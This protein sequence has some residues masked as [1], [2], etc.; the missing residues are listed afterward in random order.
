MRFR[1]YRL[2]CRAMGPSLD[3]NRYLARVTKSSGPQLALS[4]SALIRLCLCRA[5]SGE[6]QIKEAEITRTAP[7]TK[8]VHGNIRHGFVCERVPH[9]TPEVPIANNA[10]D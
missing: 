1:H 7:S 2:C 9:V 10:G 3:N 5:D 8:P 4:G 6:G